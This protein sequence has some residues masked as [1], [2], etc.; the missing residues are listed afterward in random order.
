M[1]LL[2][3]LIMPAAVSGATDKIAKQKSLIASLQ[4]QVAE[5]DREIASLKKSRA[6]N[7]QRAASLARQVE[8]RNRLLEEQRKQEIIL[9]SEISSRSLQLE[10]LSRHLDDEQQKYAQM[11]RE[12]YRSYS[13]HNMMTYLFSAKDF[14][15][16]A[17]RVANMRAVAELRERRIGRIDSLQ[18]EVTIQR[19]ELESR[20]ASHD[21]VTRDLTIQKSR[22]QSDVKS[23]KANISAMTLKERKALQ[24]KQ[25][26]QQQLTAAVRELQKLIKGNQQGASFSNKTSNLNL[27][28]VGG[29]V[30]QY[31]GNMAEVVG[32]KGSKVISIYEGKVVDVKQNRITGRYDVYIAHGEYVSSYAGLGAVSVKKNQSIARNGTIGVIGE[33]VDIIT[34]QSEYKVVFGIYPPTTNI[35]VSAAS[36]FKKK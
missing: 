24:Q 5:G 35:H 34:M 15:D 18:T 31:R 3:L 28:V 4:R 12:A 8:L 32:A 2:L 11:V 22:L 30:K 25:L 36:C 9:R 26:Q 10:D 27:P 21:K 1:S 20:K 7:E 13:N 19:K 23:A 29:R 17:R 6:A 33:A 16:I 14:Q